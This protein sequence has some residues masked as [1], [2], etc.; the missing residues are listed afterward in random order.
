MQRDAQPV[1]ARRAAYP[2]EDDLSQMDMPACQLVTTAV[3][4]WKNGYNRIAE[5]HCWLLISDRC[6]LIADR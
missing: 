6:L 4:N 1:R 3:I 5:C 2:N